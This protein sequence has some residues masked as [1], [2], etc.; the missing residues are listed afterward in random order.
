[1]AETEPTPVLEQKEFC[2]SAVHK[3]GDEDSDKNWEGKLFFAP[4]NKFHREDGMFTSGAAGTY[5]VS[6]DFKDVILKWDDEDLGQETLTTEDLGT[7]FNNGA[8][9]RFSMEGDQKPPEWFRDK[10][11]DPE[12]GRCMKA[13]PFCCPASITEHEGEPET[14]AQKVWD[15]VEHAVEKLDDKIDK[16]EE[17]I[18][19]VLEKVVE[20]VQDTQESMLRA[21][22]LDDKFKQVSDNTLD[23]V[24]PKAGVMVVDDAKTHIPAFESLDK[25]TSK[26]ITGEA[27][28]GCQ[29]TILSFRQKIHDFCDDVIE[30]LAEGIQGAVNCLHKV[31][32]WILRACKEGVK[33][34]V[35]ML[36]KVIPDCC[37]A[38]CL[39]CMGLTAKLAHWIATVMNKLIDM[40]EDCIKAGLSAVGVPEW[41][42]EKVDFN[43]NNKPDAENLPTD[44]D[45]PVSKKK[46]KESNGEAA[47]QQEAM[48]E[49][50]AV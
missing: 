19:D 36:K 15:K 30:F 41:I 8:G 40:V 14:F 28:A 27:Q 21:I 47:P 18:E 10:F 38:A 37:E 50:P 16:I 4:D 43:G 35:D 23:D 49:Q 32:S 9:F 22:G 45:E 12:D 11:T 31:V 26:D 20:A 3:V 7:S 1:M 25:A 24:A 46:L 42:C 34:A 13:C 6:K 17:K 29:D 44:D 2:F 48:E 33:F 5:A 39:S